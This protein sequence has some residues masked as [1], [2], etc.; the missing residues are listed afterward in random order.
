MGELKVLRFQLSGRTAFFKKPGVNTYGYF[1]YGMV[2]KVALLGIFGAILGYGGYTKQHRDKT[3]YPEFYEKLSG[4]KI[5]ILP[6]E[7]GCFAKKMLW[8]FHLIFALMPDNLPYP[9]LI[10]SVNSPTIFEDNPVRAVQPSYSIN[11]ISVAFSLGV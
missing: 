11:N 1:T 6:A 10:F 2:H 7:N 5:A 3:D 4:L 8:K 9:C